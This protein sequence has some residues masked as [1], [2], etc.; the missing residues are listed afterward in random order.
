MENLGS[1]YRPSPKAKAGSGHI[2]RTKRE[3]TVMTSVEIPN[4]LRKRAR[5][6]TATHGTLLKEMIVEGLTEW[7][8]AKEKDQ[9]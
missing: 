7:L 3:T 6:Y 5:L 1:S 8:D 4:S 2:S 9:K